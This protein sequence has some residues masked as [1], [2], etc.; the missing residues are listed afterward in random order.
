MT[1][2]RDIEL[3]KYRR[4]VCRHGETKLLCISGHETHICLANRYRRCPGM[5]GFGAEKLKVV[6]E[7][8]VNIC[9]DICL[10]G[11]LDFVS[12]CDGFSSSSRLYN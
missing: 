2:R 1:S 11:W 12:I 8:S 6:G 5:L 3:E 10:R 7:T 9:M 4:A